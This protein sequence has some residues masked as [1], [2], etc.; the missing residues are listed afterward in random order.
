MIISA[1]AVDK[2]GRKVFMAIMLFAT[3]FFL[4]PLMLD[5]SQGLTTAFL[6]A[7]RICI[8]ASFT[9]VYIYAPEVGILLS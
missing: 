7:A 5:E 2:V 6:S 9:V 3:F 8:T 1:I 4:C